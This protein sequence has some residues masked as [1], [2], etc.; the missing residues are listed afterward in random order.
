MRTFDV[1]LN[2]GKTPDINYG[3]YLKDCDVFERVTIDEEFDLDSRVEDA[4]VTVRK[5]SVKI[6]TRYAANSDDALVLIVCQ[7]DE[8]NSLTIK[9]DGLNEVLAEAEWISTKD[10]TDNNRSLL[11]RLHPGDRV[12]VFGYS[13]DNP[14]EGWLPERYV[15]TWNG[16]DLDWENYDCTHA[17]EL[18]KLSLKKLEGMD[19]SWFSSEQMGCFVDATINLARKAMGSKDRKSALKFLH[20]G[21][22]AAH[23][24]PVDMSEGTL[25]KRREIQDELLK[26]LK[27]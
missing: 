6:T 4:G 25:E 7:S 24:H 10:Q 11:V 16:S 21:L 14:S 3:I 15:L 23:A 22:V 18:E 9:L 5:R 26:L 27:K 2:E 8:H 13:Y 17:E 1:I 20:L 12:Q 19:P